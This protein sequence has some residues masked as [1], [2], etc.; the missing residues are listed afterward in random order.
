MHCLSV[1]S[2]IAAVLFIQPSLALAQSVSPPA[3]KAPEI[4]LEDLQG[5]TLTG[6]IV[7]SGRTRWS[8]DNVVRP[9]YQ[10]WQFKI[11]LGKDASIKW[12]MVVHSKHGEVRS[13]NHFSHSAVI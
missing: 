6:A 8:G 10:N 12:S 11:Q 2:T 13:T 1:V 5:T 7:Y 4:K 9:Q 3:D